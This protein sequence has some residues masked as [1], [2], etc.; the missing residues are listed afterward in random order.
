MSSAAAAVKRR[1]PNADAA[2]LPNTEGRPIA[3]AKRFPDA[4]VEAAIRENWPPADFAEAFV[5]AALERSR[6]TIH[7]YRK[8]ASKNRVRGRGSRLSEDDLT[9]LRSE[10][11]YR[12]STRRASRASIRPPRT[13]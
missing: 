11:K 8:T 1:F 13:R 7:G 3:F 5:G 2:T 6:E 12:G 10:E 4:M 9:F